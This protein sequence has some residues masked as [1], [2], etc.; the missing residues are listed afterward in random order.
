MLYASKYIAITFIKQKTREV[1][2]NRQK[3]INS[4]ISFS[5][6]KKKYISLNNKMPPCSLK[7]PADHIIKKLTCKTKK[8]SMADLKLNI[9]VLISENGLNSY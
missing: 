1:Q 5:R 7:R 3:H 8:Y 9:P 4:G 2:K 6:S